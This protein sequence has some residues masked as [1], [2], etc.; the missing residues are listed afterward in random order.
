MAIDW[1]LAL[2]A[3]GIIGIPIAIGL[4]MAATTSGEFRFVRGCATNVRRFWRCRSAAKVRDE[5]APSRP[6]SRGLRLGEMSK[7]MI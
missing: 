1:G 2:G 4:T 3:V 5:F 6:R 7:W